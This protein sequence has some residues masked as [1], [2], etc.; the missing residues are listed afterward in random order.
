MR[1][2]L[3]HRYQSI[4]F[5]LRSGEQVAIFLAFPATL[6]N[7]YDFEPLAENRSTRQSMFSSRS[8]R[9]LG[10]LQGHFQVGDGLFAADSREAIQKLIQ[11]IARRQ[12]LYQDLH[13]HAG[14]GE[15][16]RP[17]HQLGVTRDYFV[18]IHRCA[19]FVLFQTILP[20]RR[21]DLLDQLLHV[22]V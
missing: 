6:G 3:V 8:T 1:D 9:K 16:Q 11:R 21:S 10:G 15:H 13:R 4:E 14:P 20:P 5:A 18:F 12:V 22:V 19:S 17:V 7:A 2:A